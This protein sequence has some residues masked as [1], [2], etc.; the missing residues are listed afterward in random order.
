MFHPDTIETED[1]GFFLGVCPAMDAFSPRQKPC[2]LQLQSHR[3]EPR[4]L[5]CTGD[6]PPRTASFF[7]HSH[8]E[9]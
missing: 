1:P 6:G 8:A 3:K 7:N 9:R 5:L 4:A 2:R